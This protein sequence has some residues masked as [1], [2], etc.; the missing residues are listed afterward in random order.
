MLATL[1]SVLSLNFVFHHDLSALYRK[2]QIL[3]RF[4]QVSHENT[5]V[6][7][8]EEASATQHQRL[9]GTEDIR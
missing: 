3:W 9:L 6:Q 4:P 8:R 1:G 2:V 7:W 5:G